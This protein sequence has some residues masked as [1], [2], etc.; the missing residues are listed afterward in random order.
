MIVRSILEDNRIHAFN[1]LVELTVSEYL[2]FAKE[3]IDSNDFQRKKVI[4]SKIKEILTADLLRGCI[5]PSIVLAISNRRV[6]A[7]KGTDEINTATRIINAAIAENDLVII[8]GL[9]RTYVLKA[10]EEDLERK[11]DYDTLHKLYDLKIRAEVYL[12][13]SRTGLLYRMITLNT[14]QTT[15]STR[16]LMEILYLDYSRVPVDGIKLVKDTDEFVVEE[17]TSSFSFKTVLDGFNSYIEKDESV[18]ERVDILDNIKSLEVINKE[19]EARQSQQEKDLFKA[20][21][22][23][24]KTFLDTLIKKSND[25]KYNQYDIPAEYRINSEPFGRSVLQIFK[26]SQAI[27]GFGAA[28]GFLKERDG[29]VLER[30]SE[31]FEALESGNDWNT[32]F[33]ELLKDFDK[34]KERSKKI[35]N[36]Q[37]FYFKYFFRG[38]LKPG[39]DHEFNFISAADYAYRILQDEKGYKD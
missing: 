16:H 10:L 31:M 14:G 19:E 39:S 11:R 24:Y 37:R 5:I 29:I 25:W 26:K 38:L 34:I 9:Q 17:N 32:A 13:L 20:F 35:G 33:L 2:A 3:I 4:K 27:T 30:A 28:L 7:I 12:G 15:M 18:I 23:A 21:L 22:L 8:D 1:V 36:D 6:A